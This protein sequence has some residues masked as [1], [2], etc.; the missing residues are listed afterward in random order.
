MNSRRTPRTRGDSAESPPLP[1]SAATR[2]F[3]L[4]RAR[5]LLHALHIVNADGSVSADMRRK[6]N[7]VVHLIGLFRPTLERI[8]KSRGSVSIVDANC[9]NSYLGFLL[10]HTVTA[11]LGTQALLHGID[12]DAERVDACRR[13]AKA[14]G[15]TGTTF[16]CGSIATAALPP[17]VDLMLSLHGCD[18]A[19]DEVL[20]R[21]VSHAISDI[22]VVPC[23]QR[24]LRGLLD[25][26]AT[27]APFLRD[28]VVAVD[29]SATFTDVIR[30]LWL[31]TKGYRTETIEFVPLEHTAKNRLI[32]AVRDGGRDLQAET[33]LAALASTLSAPPLLLQEPR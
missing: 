27:F 9:G 1:A 8:A 16:F 17:V 29:F 25:P 19:T 12:R 3:D 26:G 18:T 31:R 23:C 11:E 5:P 2:A 20:K 6:L 33:E 10:H 21:A 13:R 14:L 24:E 22:Q 30:S 28:G 32:R 15:M 4:D 7:Q